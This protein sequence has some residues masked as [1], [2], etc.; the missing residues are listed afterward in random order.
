MLFLFHESKHFFTIEGYKILN[1]S[2]R[3][4]T[5]WHQPFVKQ[6]NLKG[7][8][9][10]GSIQILG[11]SG[12]L[13]S[14]NQD[15]NSF[16]SSAD[17]RL[18]TIEGAFSTSVDTR[19]DS[20]EGDTHTHANKANLDTINQNLSTTSNVTFN[21]GSFTGDMTIT[22]DLTVLGAATEISSTELR[23]EDKLI[24][25][26]SGSADSAAADGAGIEIDG[27]GKS[28]QWDHNTTSFVFDA[29]VSSSV[30]F[31]GEGGELTGID[32]DQVTEGSL[33]LIHI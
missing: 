30:G 12:I 31:K 8:V 18:D 23:I 11:G 24:T 21:T 10:S 6:V 2:K 17:S 22:G 25:V 32:T 29:K 9:I 4:V 13:S 20:L 33:S 16:S 5:E 26:A 28:L 7:G 1:A 15:F 27:A 3:E 19:L 14:S